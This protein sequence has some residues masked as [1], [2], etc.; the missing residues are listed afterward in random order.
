MPIAREHA[1]RC[2]FRA[3]KLIYGCNLNRTRKNGSEIDTDQA[4]IGALIRDLTRSGP[5][6]ILSRNRP[7]GSQDALDQ[8]RNRTLVPSER[9]DRSSSVP[10]PVNASC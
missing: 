8:E 7:C 9:F 6:P 3:R 1:R 2:T 10:A 5:L 4:G